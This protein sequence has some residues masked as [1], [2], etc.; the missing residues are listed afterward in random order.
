LRW[1]PDRQASGDADMLATAEW[2]MREV[3]AA[4]EVLRSPGDRAAYDDQLRSGS[5]TGRSSASV[6]RSAPSFEGQLVDPRR[7]DPR[8]GGAGRHRGRWVPVLIVAV[9]VLVGLV[10]AVS[11]SSRHAGQVDEPVV[12]TNRYAVG[13]CVA[14][15]PGPVVLVVPC[16][17]PNS[18]RVAATTDYPR[19]CPSGTETV[20]VVADQVSVCLAEP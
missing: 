4:W 13:S 10:L 12:R 2:H 1:H 9:L 15:Q 16:D 7:I 18:G 5:I 8:A 11:T 14:V 17:G 6:D 20:S 3:S 19:P